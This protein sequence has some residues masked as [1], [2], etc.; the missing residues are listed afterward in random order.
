MP[1]AASARSISSINDRVAVTNL[2]RQII[3]LQSTV[4]KLKTEVAGERI[5][6]INPACVVRKYE[7]FF[8]PENA[9]EFPFGEYDYVVDAIDT[10]KG[11]IGI[12]KACAA[13]GVP[14]SAV[15]AREINWTRRPSR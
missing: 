4:G 8:L 6:D 9:G 3:A 11:K 10:V 5:L 13:A 1:E 2:N 12:V 14:L 15:W 7:R